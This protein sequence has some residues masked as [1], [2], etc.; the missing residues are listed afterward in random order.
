MERS[1]LNDSGNQHLRSECVCYLCFTI[2][3]VV[4]EQYL[5]ES[6][7]LELRH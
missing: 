4:S 6:F 1:V 2:F 5:Q 3:S 7:G